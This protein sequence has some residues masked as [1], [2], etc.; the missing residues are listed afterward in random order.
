MRPNT[1][2]CILVGVDAFKDHPED[3]DIG[4]CDGGY[5]RSMIDYDETFDADDARNPPEDRTDWDEEDE[6]DYEGGIPI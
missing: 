4:E 1:P 5:L 2:R 3:G 6:D